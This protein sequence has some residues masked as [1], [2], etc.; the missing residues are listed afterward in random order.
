MVSISF[1]TLTNSMCLGPGT[2]LPYGAPPP[3]Q[4]QNF[5]CVR[6][7]AHTQEHAC[8]SWLMSLYHNSVTQ[9]K[10]PGS[11]PVLDPLDKDM[12]EFGYVNFGPHPTW[13]WGYMNFRTFPNS[14]KDICTIFK[15]IMRILNNFTQWTYWAF[16]HMLEYV[17]HMWTLYPSGMTFWTLRWLLDILNSTCSWAI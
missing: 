13:W 1:E 16:F 3:P 4:V 8:R 2:E 14:G 9:T 10:I 11:T 7:R 6:A 5:K 17:M 15:L 12:W